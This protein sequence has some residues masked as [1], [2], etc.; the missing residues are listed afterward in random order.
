MMRRPFPSAAISVSN[1]AICSASSRPLIVKATSPFSDLRILNTLFF[2]G[3]SCLQRCRSSTNQ[4]RLKV[5]VLLDL[6]IYEPRQFTNFVNTPRKVG[7]NQAGGPAVFRI[8]GSV[9][10]KRFLLIL[11][12]LIFDSRVVPGTPSLAAAPDGPD[13][14]PRHSSKA[15]SIRAFS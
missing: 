14:R 8:E 11:S 4:K 1:S 6:V 10:L 9:P 5:K 12:A 7:A 3:R 2:Q 15:A 13:T